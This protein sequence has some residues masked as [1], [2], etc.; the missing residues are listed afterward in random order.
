MT[1]ESFD[2]AVQL[3]QTLPGVG[4]R[5]AVRM[6][7]HLLRS[8]EHQVRQLAEGL[9]RLKQEIGFC[10]KCGGLSDQDLCQVCTDSTRQTSLLCIVEEPGDIFAIENTGEYHGCYHVLMG[11]LSPLDG[12]GPEDLRLTELWQRLQEDPVQEIFIATNP[13][14]EGDATANYIHEK[15]HVGKVLLT[16]LSHGIATGASIEY[17][18][19]SSLARSVKARAQYNG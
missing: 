5:S 10:Q 9:L 12:V 4:S 2:R 17:A 18:D 3:I 16:R 1:P 14:L 8:E 19:R 7:M 11:A 6:V 13:T 15:L